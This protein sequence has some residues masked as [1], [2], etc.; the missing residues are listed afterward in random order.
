MSFIAEIS[1]A[2]WYLFMHRFR[3]AN[4]QTELVGINVLENFYLSGIVLYKGTALPNEVFE[5]LVKEAILLL[6]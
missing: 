6:P 3:Q 1:R 2:V 5:I 4:A